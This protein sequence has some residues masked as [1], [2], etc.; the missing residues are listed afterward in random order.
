MTV[1]GLTGGIGSGKSAVAARMAAH[2]GVRVVFADDLARRLMTDDAGLR[3]ALAARFGADTFGPD[4]RLDRARL[5]ARVFHDPAE[6][7]ALDAL[8][9]PAV[10]RAMRAEIDAARAAGVR[11][12]VYEAALL[13]EVG[14]DAL[15]DRV[16][17]VTAPDALRLARAMARDGVPES[18]V[19]ARMARQ[20]DPAEA[21]RRTAA[22]AGTVVANDADL[23]ALHVRTDALVADLLGR[24]TLTGP[25]E[26]R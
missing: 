5:A 18:D 9:H 20:M 13:F 7:D 4:G 1:V 6:L 22:A 19:R 14:A 15:V 8:V 11:L 26:V 2:A 12:F 17:L 24:P 23:A 10:R 21:E 16:V 25:G 3:A